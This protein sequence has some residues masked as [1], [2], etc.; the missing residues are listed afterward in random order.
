CVSSAAINARRER[1]MG[2]A[3]AIII[4]IIIASTP[5]LL[6]AIGELVAERSGVHNLGVEG[7]MIMGAVSGFIATV[8]S[9]S[10]FVGIIAAILA[11][12][13]MACLFA[14]LTLVLLANQVATG[15]ALALLGLGLSALIGEDYAS[16]AGIKL[17]K[18][19]ITGITD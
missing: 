2:I 10:P 6:A 15:L 14:F 17:S 18:I 12:M 9:G 11:G 1:R 5:L 13:A 19:H 3:K 16:R 7:M 8:E 4:S